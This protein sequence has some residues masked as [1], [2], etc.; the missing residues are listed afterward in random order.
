MDCLLFVVV[1]GP[2]A[3]VMIFVCWWCCWRIL[4][5]TLAGFIL[6]LSEI[7]ASTAIVDVVH[8]TQLLLLYSY[9]FRIFN[10]GSRFISAPS[11]FLLF[12][13]GE[14]PYKPYE[15]FAVNWIEVGLR[16]VKD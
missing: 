12:W 2:A 10:F 15:L 14:N 5:V 4:F 16:F 11:R 13:G 6:A 3:I 7:A 8:R 9:E 1:V